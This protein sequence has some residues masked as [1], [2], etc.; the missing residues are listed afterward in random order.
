[1]VMTKIFINA[2]YIEKKRSLN[3]DWRLQFAFMKKESLVIVDQHATVNMFL[4]S[5]HTA[6]QGLK[7]G[8]VLSFFRK[9]VLKELLVKGVFN[10]LKIIQ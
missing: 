7:G 4:G 8:A 10:L 3:S 2:N 6:R 1:M 9:R 5:V